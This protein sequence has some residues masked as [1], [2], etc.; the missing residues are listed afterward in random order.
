MIF[1]PTKITGDIVV[2]TKWC[3]QCEAPDLFAALNYYAMC[4]DLDAQVIRTCYRPADHQKATKLW[5]AANGITKEE[6]KNYPDFVVYNGVMGL[7]EFVENND[8]QRG[9][10]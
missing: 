2:Y 10:E 5:S 7:K 9:R 6:A 3:L 1:R 8:N 4:N